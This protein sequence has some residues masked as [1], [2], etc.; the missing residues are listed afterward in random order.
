[1]TKAIL[2]RTIF[3]TML[4]LVPLASY[5]P[6]SAQ[7]ESNLPKSLRIATHPVGAA[8]YVLGSAFAKV[9]TNAL[10]LSATVRP[11]SG[12]QAWFPELNRNT[13]Q[14]GLATAYDLGLAWKGKAP[15]H[16]IPNVRTLSVGTDLILGLGVKADSPIKTL[17]D[18]KGKRVTINMVLKGSR[19]GAEAQ[20]RAAGIDP[21]T[22]IIVIPVT[23]VVQPIQMLEEGRVDAAWGSPAAPQFKEAAVRLGGVRFLPAALNDTQKHDIE[24]NFTGY[25]VIKVKGGTM[26]GVKVDTPLMASPINLV[27][28]T[29][30]SDETAYQIIK[31]IWNNYD[32]Y[33]GMH[34]WARQWTHKKMAANLVNSVV[35]F[36]AGAVRFYKEIGV[37][38]NAAEK[39]QQK[40]LAGT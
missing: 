23:N 26:T 15:Y 28:N 18:L 17:A 5:L 35:P 21:K 27:V 3:A 39:H 31:A 9:L 24:K 6:A 32:E 29:Q 4:V 12:F 11:F 20:L 30:M 10:P 40:L 36:H 38:S 33:K 8:Y 25:R 16:K 34:P 19:D 1:M 14:M 37:W 2:K 22:G 7:A 13:V